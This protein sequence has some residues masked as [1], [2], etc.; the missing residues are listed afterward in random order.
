MVDRDSLRGKVKQLAMGHRQLSTLWGI[1]QQIQRVSQNP[2]S[3]ARDLGKIISSDIVLSTRVLRVINSAA[4]G[5]SYKIRDLDQAIVLLGHR[6]VVD[7]CTS[8]TAIRSM[9]D[10]TAATKFDRPSFWR[11]SLATAEFARLLQKRVIGKEDPELFAAGLLCNIGR[12]IL[13]Q[14]LPDEFN[15]V[16]THAAKNG[17]SLLD[18]EQEVLGAT[19]AEIGS[20]AASAWKIDPTL[21][22]AI[23][24][25][26]GPIGS[27]QWAAVVNVAYVYAQATDAGS[28]GEQDLT[29]LATGT[30]SLLKL[31]NVRL[32]NLV[33]EMNMESSLLEPAFKAMTD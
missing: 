24:V 23:R 26:H 9:M 28:P 5:F 31:D 6:R 8:I 29:S 14:F 33:T 25:H 17:T 15:A 21:C 10:G 19:H 22:E 11:H 12:I 13:D 30:L 16:M 18:A 27:N 7:L 2:R 4:Y 20:W 32:K 3:T 1:V